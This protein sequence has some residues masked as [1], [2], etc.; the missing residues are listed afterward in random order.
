MTSI[1][2]GKIL[3]SLSQGSTVKDACMG[4]KCSPMSFYRWVKEDPEFAEGVKEAERELIASVE[5]AIYRKAMYGDKDGLGH[6]GAQVFILCNR[7][8]GKWKDL[9]YV[10]HAGQI[11]VST[12]TA[13]VN[14]LAQEEKKREREP[15]PQLEAQAEDPESSVH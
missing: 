15:K 7:S 6:F 4:A 13:L 14:Q 2:K 3:T 12:F 11:K 8:D 1:K 5:A 10:E 9:K